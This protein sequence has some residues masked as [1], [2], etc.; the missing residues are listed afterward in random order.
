MTNEERYEKIVREFKSW[1]KKY[2]D[3]LAAC[4]YGKM[5]L[6]SFM[7]NAILAAVVA[8]SDPRLVA[9]FNENAQ[10]LEACA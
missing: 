7:S 2:E 3:A 5:S 9:H 8:S 4:E 10:V 6:C 1:T